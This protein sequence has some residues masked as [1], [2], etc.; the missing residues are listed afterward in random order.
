MRVRRTAFFLAICAGAA[1]LA[2]QNSQCADFPTTQNTRQ[3]CDA[4]IDLTRAYHPIAGLLVSGGNAVLGSGATLGGLGKFAFTLRVNA[5]RAVIPNL[6]VDANN[7]VT[8]SRDVLA[9]APV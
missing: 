1:P 9:P 7:N 6:V 3:S 8:K 2:A 4:A 5:T